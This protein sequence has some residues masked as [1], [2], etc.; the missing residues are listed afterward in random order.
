MEPGKKAVDEKGEL[1]RD[2]KGQIVHEYGFKY[3]GSHSTD[4]KATFERIRNA[5]KQ[6]E[7]ARSTNVKPLK[8]R[9]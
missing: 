7:L 2:E 6:P 1:V 8:P 4:L 3:R 9:K 5:Q